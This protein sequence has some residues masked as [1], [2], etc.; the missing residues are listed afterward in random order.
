MTPT[1]YDL[2]GTTVSSELP[3]EAV[4]TDLAP[5][6]AFR[7]GEPVEVAGPPAGA[8]TSA[9]EFA[10]LSYWLADRGDDWLLRFDGFA[11][12]EI[13]EGEI[14]ARPNPGT[15]QAM[16]PLMLVGGV[17]A[18]VLM[19][20]GLMVLHA[21]AVEIEGRAI[22]I[23][24]QTGMGKSTTAA[25][26]CASGAPLL[27]DDTLAID[28]GGGRPVGYRGTTALR[29]REGAERLLELFPR[30][31]RSRTVDGRNALRPPVAA[32]RRLELAAVVD[33]TRTEATR[34]VDVERLSGNQA[35]L[36][37]LQNPRVS[38]WR[39]IE[40]T[41]DHFEQS[42]VVAQRVPVLRAEVPAPARIG[43]RTVTDLRAA[44]DAELSAA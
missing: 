23:V 26:L 17:L 30:E 19:A 9:L 34:E 7:V 2:H 38:G 5:E 10:G 13:R 29:L 27:T 40:R 6:R 11:D 8:V 28:T 36:A 42:S 32:E 12:F 35:A 39:Q 21:S 4:A 24:G 43:E 37:L 31:R 14:V 18:H 41:R 33:L 3:I 1:T 20:G 22:A 44:I 15:D 16:L 25:L